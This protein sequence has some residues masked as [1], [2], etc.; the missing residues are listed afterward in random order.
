MQ[1]LYDDVFMTSRQ[2]GDM[3]IVT[4]PRPKCRVSKFEIVETPRRGVFTAE[5]PFRGETEN[6]V[7]DGIRLCIYSSIFESECL[8]SLSTTLE[9]RWAA[10][11]APIPLILVVG[12]LK[13]LLARGHNQEV[14]RRTLLP[15]PSQ[16]KNS[17]A[18]ILPNEN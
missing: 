17:E 1:R 8:H 11:H 4:R 14:V 6:I 15:P 13:H 18:A 10:P 5:H 7:N 3:G 12:N 16:R 9:F 2:P